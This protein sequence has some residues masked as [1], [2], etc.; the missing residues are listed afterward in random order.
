MVYI[1]LF[2]KGDRVMLWNNA[3]ILLFIL[4]LIFII[5][6]YFKERKTYILLLIPPTLGALFFQT[7]LAQ[8]ISKPVRIGLISVLGAMMTIIFY[9]LIRDSKASKEQ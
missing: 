5:V 2:K 3:N 7:S 8:S 6:L 9:I 1:M 4:L